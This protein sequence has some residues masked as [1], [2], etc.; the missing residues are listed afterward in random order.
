MERCRSCFG[1]KAILSIFLLISLNSVVNACPNFS[2]RYMDK[3]NVRIEITQNKC[4]EITFY[5]SDKKT[6]LQLDG[7]SRTHETGDKQKSS[8]SGK[9][10]Q[11]ELILEQVI[12]N[13]QNNSK[14][15]I[16]KMILTYSFRDS[17]TLIEDTKLYNQAN[18]LIDYKT[19]TLL[20]IKSA[21]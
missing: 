20:K 14:S 10:S 19:M 21:N 13:K 1:M 8:I 6:S 4:S 16:Y 15:F 2:G 5:S 12:Y 18:K 17:E 11:K 7:V 9:L 3:E